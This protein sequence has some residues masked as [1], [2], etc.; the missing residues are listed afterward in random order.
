MNDIRRT[1]LWVIFG[2][3]LV[4]LWDKWQIHNGRKPTFFPTPEVTAQASADEAKTGANGVPATAAPAANASNVP[5]TASTDG[6]PATA[7]REKVTVTTDLYKLTFDGEGG[8][9]VG[10]EL[11]KYTDQEDKTKPVKLLDESAARVYVAQTGLIG[12]D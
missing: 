10:A 12:G 6:T 7:A 5:G 3:S 8:S 2:F 9:L 11:L 4:L 1:I